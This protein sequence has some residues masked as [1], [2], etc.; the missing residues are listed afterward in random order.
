MATSHWKLF[1]GGP[2]SIVLHWVADRLSFHFP[3]C[4]PAG[5]EENT[6][7]PAYGCNTKQPKVVN[8]IYTF[9]KGEMNKRNVVKMTR[10]RVVISYQRRHVELTESNKGG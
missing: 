1:V 9:H 6:K 10:R 3:L 2:L 7:S 4:A 8:F 5:S